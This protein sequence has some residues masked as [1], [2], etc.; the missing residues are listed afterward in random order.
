ML[1]TPERFDWIVHFLN[2]SLWEI[3]KEQIQ[4]ENTIPFVILD[5]YLVEQ[6]PSYKLSMLEEAEVVEGSPAK[7]D[8]LFI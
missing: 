5:K 1:V 7:K 6:A 3:I 4:N 2:S 8:T